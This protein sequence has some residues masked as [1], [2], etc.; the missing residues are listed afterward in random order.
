VDA[1]ANAVRDL[2]WKAILPPLAGV[3][4]VALALFFLLD[5]QFLPHATDSLVERDEA[6]TTALAN[7]VEPFLV[8]KDVISA[9]A[10]MD[11]ILS[12][13]DVRWAYVTGPDGS[14][15]MDSFV[16]Q[17]P[18]DLKRKIPANVDHAWIKFAGE[19]SPTLVIRKPVL[20]G[21]VG[22]VWVGFSNTRPIASVR[23]MERAVVFETVLIMGAVI[24]ILAWFPGPTPA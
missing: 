18:P 5:W 14:M 22:T 21:I 19:R 6:I 11:P 10:A 7:A 3:I 4:F 9:Q 12:T 2:T 24:V 17:V 16:P 8:A 20:A 1:G 23:A 15:L 13:P